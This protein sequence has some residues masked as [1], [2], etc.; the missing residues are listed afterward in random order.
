MRIMPRHSKDVLTPQSKQMS[1]LKDFHSSLYSGLKGKEEETKR[2]PPTRRS[3][4]PIR[5][6]YKS[7]CA[8]YH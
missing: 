4:I 3:E 6:S 8:Q 1:A 5:A 7:E 2:E